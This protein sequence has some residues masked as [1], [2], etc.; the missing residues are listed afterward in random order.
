[1]RNERS[2]QRKES[3]GARTKDSNGVGPSFRYWHV[4]RE[5]EKRGGRG[6][7]RREPTLTISSKAESPEQA[8]DMT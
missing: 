8:I 6:G 5:K 7:S 3:W 4:G 1:M 2:A